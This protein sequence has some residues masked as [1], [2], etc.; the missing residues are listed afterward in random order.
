MAERRT[1]VLPDA[2]AETGTQPLSNDVSAFQE[3]AR[4]SGGSNVAS[5][6]SPGRSVLP[7]LADLRSRGL[8]GGSE[9][10][11]RALA[12]DRRCAAGVRL[13]DVSDRSSDAED[14]TQAGDAA[15]TRVVSA[16]KVSR[17]AKLAGAL[18]LAATLAIVL[19]GVIAISGFNAATMSGVYAGTFL[20]LISL[21]VEMGV[22]GRSLRR[23]E[24][25][26]LQATLRA[27]ILRLV[28]VGSVGTWFA[29]A[30]S[31]SDAPAYC[32][33]YCATF[34]VYMCWLT[35]RTYHQ[36]VQYQG[37]RERARHAAKSA[38]TPTRRLETVGGAA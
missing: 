13:G 34:F 23:F 27:F 6:H 24:D 35:W 16:P 3:D 22:I 25:D 4:R 2:Q 10:G 32:L 15:T 18:S 33:S 19:W 38:S 9:A 29:R 7:D 17:R 1:K 37:Q 36:P 30:G 21:V 14:L 28:L 11:V 31:G 8:V 12:D 26:G 5:L 20:G